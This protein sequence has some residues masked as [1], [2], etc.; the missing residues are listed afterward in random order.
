MSEQDEVFADLNEAVSSGDFGTHDGHG[1]GNALDGYWFA[2][3]PCGVSKAGLTGRAFDEMAEEHRKGKPIDKPASHEVVRFADVA[4]YERKPMD[5]E[6]GGLRP[7][8]TMS[9]MTANP[10]RVMAAAAELYRGNVVH[11]PSDIDTDTA[12][13]WLTEMTKTKLGA[14][15]EFID[16]TFLL[17]NVT[18]A[19][20]H[21]LVRQRV[22]AVYIQES[23][24]FSVAT[25]GAHEVRQAPGIE[26]LEDDDPRRVVWDEATEQITTAYMQLIQAG[27]PA[28]DARGILP[29]NITTRIWYKTNLRGLI[30]HSG[31]RLCTQAQYEWKEVWRGIIAAILTNGH[32]TLDELWQRREII[33]MF[34]PVCYATGKC[35]FMAQSDRWCAIRSRVERHHQN[36][37]PS[38]FWDDINPHESL[39]E[40]AARLSP[41][42]AR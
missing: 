18:R 33:K 7:R 1:L 6:H 23:M 38:E 21:Q 34:R 26:T 2:C 41:D 30:E 28:E 37:T 16:F 24:R 17:E 36:G 19:F 42:Q 29:T 35:E 39:A 20:T 15:L 10:L 14:P 40:G 5:R 12:K 27:V 8:V 11:N 25:N 22:G 13:F 32:P 31:M 9:S 4:M 3:D